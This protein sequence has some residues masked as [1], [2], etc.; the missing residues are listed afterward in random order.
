MQDPIDPAPDEVSSAFA[1]QPVSTGLSD[2]ATTTVAPEAAPRIWPVILVVLASILT[3]IMGTGIAILAGQWIATGSVATTQAEAIKAM[4]A[5]KD[6]RWAF[7][8]TVV[9]PQIALVV[10]AVVASLLSPRGFRQRLRLVRGNWPWWGWLAAALATPLVGLVA[11][12][13]AGMFLEESEALKEMTKMFRELGRSGFLIP[14]ALMIGGMPAICEEFLFRGYIQTRLNRRWGPTIGIL[15]AST[16]F[17][18]FHLDPVHAIGVFPIGLWMGWLAYR[19]GS[20]I[21]AMIAHMINNVLAVVGVVVDPSESPEA[22]AVPIAIVAILI[23]GGGFIGMIGVTA[24]TF[25]FPPQ[26]S[27][28]EPTLVTETPQANG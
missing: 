15:V 25:F 17:A 13:G 8:L 4:G 27:T 24:A 21:P 23:L 18:I 11:S 7:T 9:L 2:E 14:L 26:K 6:S 1:Y 5:I 16:I 28:V 3:F 22:F 19:S 20:I 10:P 12:I